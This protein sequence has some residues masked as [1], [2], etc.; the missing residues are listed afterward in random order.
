MGQNFPW[1]IDSAICVGVVLHGLFGSQPNVSCISFKLPG[2]R[3]GEVGL[4]FL[5]LLGG[6]YSFVSSMALAPYR[7][8]YALAI[9]GFIC[10]A[11]RIMERRKMARGD[12][13]SRKSWK[14][15]HKH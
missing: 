9:I 8:L 15:S 13:S 1:F 11:S 14:H 10:F 12:V 6:F 7:A 4:S 5:Y 3:G 2:R